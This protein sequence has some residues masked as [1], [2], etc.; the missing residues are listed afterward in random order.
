MADPAIEA[1]LD[2]FGIFKA[3]FRAAPTLEGCLKGTQRCLHRQEN[4]GGFRQIIRIIHKAH[5][6]SIQMDGVSRIITEVT[7]DLL[8]KNG[9]K[10]FSQSLVPE[11]QKYDEILKI[12]QGTTRARQGDIGTSGDLYWWEYPSVRPRAW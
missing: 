7:F 11:I 10:S 12:R 3:T 1:V 4:I 5:K 2:I 8:G 9:I 6:N